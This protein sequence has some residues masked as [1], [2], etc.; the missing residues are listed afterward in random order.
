MHPAAFV[1]DCWMEY[2]CPVDPDWFKLSVAAPPELVR[3]MVAAWLP[4][5]DWDVVTE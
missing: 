2:T 1:H 4:V 5:P 3:S